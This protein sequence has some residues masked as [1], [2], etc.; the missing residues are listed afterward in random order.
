MNRC[1]YCD[2]PI[3]VPTSL[4]ATVNGVAVLLLSCPYCWKLVGIVNNERE[5]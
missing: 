1:P 3:A 5:K 4:P 2:R